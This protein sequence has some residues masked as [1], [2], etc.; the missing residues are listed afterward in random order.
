MFSPFWFLLHS[1]PILSALSS[2]PFASKRVLLWPLTY[3]RLTA[4][5]SPY[6]GAFK[7]PQD[8]GPR[9]PLMPEKAI[10]CYIYIWSHG[11]LYIY[12]LVGGHHP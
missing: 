5:A 6:T 9:L 8:Q 2:F 10:L 12:S 1:P 4:L 11:S 3:S 7:S